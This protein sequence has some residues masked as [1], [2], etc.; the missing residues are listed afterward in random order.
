[1]SHGSRVANS[2]GFDR[3]FSND[4]YNVTAVECMPSARRPAPAPRRR[5][6]ENSFIFTYIIT[7]PVKIKSQGRR[8]PRAFRFLPESVVAIPKRSRHL[9]KYTMMSSRESR[10]T[11]G[12][13]LP[14]RPSLRLTGPPHD[15]LLND[16]G[17][18]C[19]HHHYL[20][21]TND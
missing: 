4:S 11:V 7:S 1:M 9:R 5:S 13:G 6:L 12:A 21:C 8:N 14:L 3:T 15:L 16:S 17:V 18:F 2:Y 10:R 19:A 20:W